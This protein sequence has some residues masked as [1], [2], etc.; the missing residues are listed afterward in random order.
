MGVYF[1]LQGSSIRPQSKN[2][3]ENISSNSQDDTN[4]ISTTNKEKKW[5]PLI[6]EEFSKELMSIQIYLITSIK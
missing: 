2:L 1:S 4:L 6:I 5:S 3:I